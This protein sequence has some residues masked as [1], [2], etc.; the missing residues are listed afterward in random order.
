MKNYPKIKLKI[1]IE[2]D[3]N[4]CINFVKCENSGKRRQFL[5]WFLPEDFQYILSKNF[6]E[7]ERNKIIKEY[8]KHIYKIR[9]DEIEKSL[10]N[11]IKDWQKVEKR[12]FQ[13]VDKIFKGHPWPKGNYRGIISIY[14][15]YPRY[16]QHK[17]F[18][19]P[20]K[21]NI[22]KF[23]NKVIA[24]EMLHFIF[25]DYLEQKY[26]LK[27]K[28]KIPGKSDEY[29]WQ[30]SEVFNNVIEVWEPYNKII[31]EKP[32]PYPATEMKK[33]WKEKQDIDWLLDQ[34]F[35]R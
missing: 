32:R 28:S 11:T 4:N 13:L 23:A 12:Y 21:H 2:R 19:F 20:Y 27:E 18:F 25:F 26:K 6:S 29:I 24:H 35:K 34:W 15:M 10:K 1:D 7:K 3:I 30:V 17:I 9:K 31:G 5:L 33:Q 22:P 14:E 16:I 8:T